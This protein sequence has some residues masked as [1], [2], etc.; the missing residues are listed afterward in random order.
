MFSGSFCDPNLWDM[1]YNEV[2]RKLR[3]LGCQ[4]LKSSGKGSHRKWYN[5][6]TNKKATIPYNNR[7]LAKGTLHAIMKTLEI[8]RK[9][10]EDA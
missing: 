1:R 5:P 4:E 7:E 10:F 2:K 3:W 6:D 8:D 9:M